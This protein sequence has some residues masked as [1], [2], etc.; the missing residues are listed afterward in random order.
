MEALA[1]ALLLAIFGNRVIEYF[2]TPLFEK[3]NVDKTYLLY[4]GAVPGFVLSVAAGIDLFA[5]LGISLAY[6]MGVYA[7][8]LAVG[9]GANL[10]HD[11]FDSN[12]EYLEAS[13][14]ETD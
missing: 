2:V 10:I 4:V 9:G 11:I 14:K 13:L 6:N 8:A 5:M 3:F 7:T 1:A 12:I